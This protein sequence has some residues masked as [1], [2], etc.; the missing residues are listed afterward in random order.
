MTT[1]SSDVDG[2]DVA[3][4]AASVIAG[5]GILLLG[6]F[7]LALPIIVLTTVFL[8]PLLAIGLVPVLVV[9]ILATP[10]LLVK[11]LQRHGR[12]PRG[13]S[14]V[15]HPVLDEDLALSHSARL[16]VDKGVRT[17]QGVR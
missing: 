17:V 12:P 14:V 11:R 13:R 6:L 5:T 4:G 16:V 8:V 7:A 2:V 3:F 15:D 9:G 10:V 1:H